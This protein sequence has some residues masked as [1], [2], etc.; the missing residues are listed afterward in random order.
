MPVNIGQPVPSATTVNVLCQIEFRKI[1]AIFGGSDQVDELPHL[2]LISRLVEEFE[3]VNVIAL[4]PKMTLD[5]V[6]NR[7]LEHE[8]VVDSD[9]PDFGVLVPARLP[10]T[11]DG[12][13]HDIIGNEEERLQLSGRQ[14]GRAYLGYDNLK[15]TSSTHQPRIAAF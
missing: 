6:V 1:Y 5:E 14:K 9:E 10:S 4:L 13:V 11:G 12:R 2:R 8:R 3:E 15:R 7:G